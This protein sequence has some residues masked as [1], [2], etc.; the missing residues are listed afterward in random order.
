MKI[1][2]LGATSQI[3]QDLLRQWSGAAQQHDLYLF[4]RRT[5]AVEMLLQT[6]DWHGQISI[7]HLDTFSSVGTIDSFDAVLNFIGVGDPSRAAT[8]THE[9]MQVTFH[10]DDMVLE[11]LSQHPTCRYIFLSSGAAYGSDF[12]HPVDENT[13]AILNVN[14]IKK[15]DIYGLA[16]LISEIKHRLL[17]DKCIFDVRVFNYFSRYQDVG[18]RFFITDIL[19]C[20]KNDE[21]CKV[22]PS[23]MI[24][25]YLHPYDFSV[26]IN[27]LLSVEFGN[28]AVDCYSK[29]PVS[30][31]ALLMFSSDKFGLKWEYS[32][33]AILVNATGFKENYYSKNFFAKSYGYE[34]C[35]SSIECIESE[36]S[37]CLYENNK[38]WD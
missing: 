14:S 38:V 10:Y 35:Y 20:I 7:H 4:A 13:S 3:A 37:A 15:S 2:I 6:L 11:Y 21:V 19:R 36:F 23:R 30:K 34:P 31:E 29:S 25:D 12:R 33:H 5:R 18:A 17:E 1:A 9:I 8:Y 24:R 27:C 28:Q 26:L 16:K 32:E 22:S